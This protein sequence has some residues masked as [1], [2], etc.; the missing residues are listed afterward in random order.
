VEKY[1]RARQATDDKIIRRMR[2][3]C[4][5]TKATDIH[6]EYEILTALPLQQ[7]LRERATMLRDT[8]TS[9]SC[10]FT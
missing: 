9:L 6:S 8:Y 5:V 10:Y 3:A 2:Y 7:W 4:W 1:V